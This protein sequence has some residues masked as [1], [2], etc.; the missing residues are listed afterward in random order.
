MAS[1]VDVILDVDPGVDD[2]MAIL[3]AL[4]APELYVLALTVVSGNVPV[5]TGTDNALRILAFAGRDDIG[6]LLYTSPSPR[7]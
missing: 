6:C 7:D 3:M 2:A 4:G 1:S 5:H